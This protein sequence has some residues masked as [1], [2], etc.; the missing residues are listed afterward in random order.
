[1]FYRGHHNEVCKIIGANPSTLKP[2][3]STY[4]FAV[5]TDIPRGQ[6]G[7]CAWH[8]WVSLPP[9]PAETIN[10]IPPKVTMARMTE[11]FCIS[12]LALAS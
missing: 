2:D 11:P 1:M 3:G 6:A 8:R 7:Y 9:S 12:L 10:I 4:Y 5:Y